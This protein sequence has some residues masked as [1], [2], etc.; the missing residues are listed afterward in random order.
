MDLSAFPPAALW[1]WDLA[2]RLLAAVVV[3]L[4]GIYALSG[5]SV[6]VALCAAMAA[7]LV[8]LSSLG[9]DLSG[10]GW[11]AVAAL[12][13][14]LA[15]I[16]GAL[17]SRL[18]GAGVALVFVLFTVHGAMIRAGLVAQIAWFTVATGGL[19][20]ALLVTDDV[21]LPDLALGAALGSVLALA[22]MWLVPRMLSAPRLPI[23]PEALAPDT[24]RLR[25]MMTAPTWRDWM[26]PLAL[27]AMSA[28]LLLA[29]TALT[30][31]FKPYWAV[32]AFVSVLAP[33]SA[34]TR[35]SA[36]ETVVATVIG[37]ALAAGV[38]ALGL[39]LA[40]EA[41]LITLLGVLGALLIIRNGTASK[42][43]LTPLPVVIAAGA[44]D[45]QG[46]LAF[47]L[48]LVEYV[49][50]ALLGAAA[51]VAAEFL[52]RRLWR[53]RDEPDVEIVG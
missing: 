17:A 3:P 46:A 24:E 52:G 39:P 53:D 51:A 21:A 6:V 4:I 20:A 35:E 1:R 5:V 14:P 25:R 19:L 42:A 37:V 22:L 11:I 29:A 47:Q 31:G 30:G 2:V 38:L 27:G 48:R 8:S 26:A 15:M 12:G 10:R 13:V 23:P 44:L 43:L 7:A 49:V 28:A 36:V 41:G 33:T 45:A 16:A 18:P 32:L 34:K 9:P 40:V 50:G